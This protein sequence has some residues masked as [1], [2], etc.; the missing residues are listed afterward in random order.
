ML[1]SS[2]QGHT[3]TMLAGEQQMGTNV[4]TTTSKPVPSPAATA[5]AS[6]TSKI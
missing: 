5:S 4:A 2:L 3:M 6:G 1:A